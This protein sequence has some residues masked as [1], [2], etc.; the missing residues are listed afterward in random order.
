MF[1]SSVSLQHNDTVHRAA[2]NDIDFTK[3]RDPRLG[4]QR[5][6]QVSRCAAVL[7]GSIL[8]ISIP[9]RNFDIESLDSS[10]GLAHCS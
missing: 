2:A 8:C 1:S 3:P 5:I 9:L 6:V 7:A 10:T 4:V